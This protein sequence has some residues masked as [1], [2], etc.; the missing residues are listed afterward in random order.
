MGTCMFVASGLDFD[1][2]A[3]FPSSPFKEQIAT[4]F[5]KGQIPT[6]DTVFGRNLLAGVQPAV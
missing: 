3:Y 6:R 1:V 2:D 4:V 5:R